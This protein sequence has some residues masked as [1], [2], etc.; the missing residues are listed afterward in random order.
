MRILIRE[1]VFSWA[2]KFSVT[3]E[4]GEARYIVEG[5]FFSWGKKL[6]VYDLQEREVAYIEQKAMSFLPRY[7][8]Y[9]GDHLIG[10]VVKE[11]SF[12]HPKYSV[13][14]AGWD[15]EGEFGEHNYTVF[16]NDCPVVSIDKDWFTWG[17]CYTLD[18]SDTQDE[19]Q[20]LAL[21]LAIDCAM[22]TRD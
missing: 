1:Q 9:V 6:R 19:I 3:D 17:D 2:D 11:I 4:N 15:V 16:K 20:A 10:E 7:C 21:V 12:F 22:E 8:V 13:R 5:Q 14:G 18:I